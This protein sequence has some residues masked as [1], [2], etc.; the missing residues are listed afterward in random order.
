MES[1]EFV[2]KLNNGTTYTTEEGTTWIDWITE[3]D[4][5]EYFDPDFGDNSLIYRNAYPLTNSNGEL[6]WSNYP[7]V[8]D[9]YIINTNFIW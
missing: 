8:A 7:I 6:V 3:N 9:D 1:K 5:T 2:E 4:M